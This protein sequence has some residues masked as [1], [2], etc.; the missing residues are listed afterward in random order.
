MD[1]WHIFRSK[2]NLLLSTSKIDLGEKGRLSEDDVE[3]RHHWVGGIKGAAEERR[4]AKSITNITWDLMKSV[5]DGA[6][7]EFSVVWSDNPIISAPPEYEEL[8]CSSI[9]LVKIPK[10]KVLG[11]FSFGG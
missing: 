3:D 11:T 1:R 7:E 2:Q 10:T 6:V 4:M 8:P 5:T 9:G